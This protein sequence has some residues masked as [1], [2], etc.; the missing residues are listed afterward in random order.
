MT[1]TKIFNFTFGITFH[2][3]FEAECNQNSI[4]LT[5]IVHHFC[6]KLVKPEQLNLIG[7]LTIYFTKHFLLENF[8]VFY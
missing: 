8:T 7:T 5:E 6:Y 1:E 4:L 2:F 3:G